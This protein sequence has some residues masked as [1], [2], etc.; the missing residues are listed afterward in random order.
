M[1]L[2]TAAG[3]TEAGWLPQEMPCGGRFKKGRFLGRKRPPRRR[4]WS[5]LGLRYTR[6]GGPI[7]PGLWKRGTRKF[8]IVEIDGSLAGTDAFRRHYHERYEQN[9]ALLAEFQ[10]SVEGLPPG[11]AAT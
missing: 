10:G 4:S 2:E 3:A 8:K 1:R 7:V 6:H 11:Y 9:I 5:S